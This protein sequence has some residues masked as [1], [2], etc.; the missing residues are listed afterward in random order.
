M[1]EMKSEKEAYIGSDTPLDSLKLGPAVSPM[2]VIVQ[3]FDVLTKPPGLTSS[4]C[5][6]VVSRTQ[7]ATCVSGRCIAHLAEGLVP[8]V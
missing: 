2:N 6:Y 1:S 4:S 5:D 8:V 3:R 7:P